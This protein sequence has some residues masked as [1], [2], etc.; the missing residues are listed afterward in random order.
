MA[1]I[2]HAWHASS[3][4]YASTFRNRRVRGSPASARAARTVGYS[5]DA[6]HCMLNHI[7]AVFVA[8]LARLGNRC[9]VVDGRTSDEDSR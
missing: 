3:R 8:D 2:Y 1:S 9:N 7:N 5:D 6:P 4:I